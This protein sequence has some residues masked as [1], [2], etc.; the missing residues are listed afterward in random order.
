MDARTSRYHEVYARWQRDPEGFW[1]EAA[2]AIDWIEPAEE[3]VRPGRRRLRP[4]V[5]RRRRATPATTR[6]T[7]MSTRGRGEQPAIIYDSPV[8]STK[9]IIT[10]AELLR[11][12]GDARGDPA[13]LRRRQGRPRHPLHADGA[14]GAVRDAGLRAHRRDPFGGVRRLR[15][16]RSSRPAS[17]TAKPKLILSASC[18]IEGAR[19]VAYKPLLDEA[20]ELA[21]H[22][23]EACLILQR[24][25]A[26]PRSTARP[27][28]RL[29]DAAR[30]SARGEQ[31]RADCVP[32]LA[33]DPLYILYTSGTTGI[34]KGVVRDN[35]GHMVALEMVDDEPLRR[36]S[37]A[38]CT[39]R[40]PTSAGW[41]ATP[42]SSTRRCFT[43]AP[44]SS[45]RASRS[46][47]RTPARSGASSPSTSASRCSPR[48]PRSARSRR[49]TRRASS[50]RNTTCRNS[51]RCSSPASAPIRRPSNGPSSC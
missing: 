39:G 34:P 2:Q 4:L 38:R 10:Y 1:G 50:S 14:G 51:A 42:T 9:R 36:R 46:A 11:R 16:R 18:G 23:P 20:I 21:T 28:P 33:T 19:V 49:K 17:T 30:R 41:S 22:K 24:P 5:R 43:A 48:R 6:S 44:R 26:R 29:G 45:T 13:G 40:P 3:G 31:V 12:G 32:V 25:Q 47:R 27:R 37:P 35:G 7:A 15:G 8:T